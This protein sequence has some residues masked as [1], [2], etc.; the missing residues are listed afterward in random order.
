M[1]FATLVIIAPEGTEAT[2]ERELLH[3]GV[4]GFSAWPVKGYGQHGH[5]PTQWAT[6]NVRIEALV[7]R[8]L[9]ERVLAELREKHPRE[10]RVFLYAT[11]AVTL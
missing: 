8:E 5:R 1:E 9:A 10:S 6:G 3:L 4:D 2:L 7:T 11:L